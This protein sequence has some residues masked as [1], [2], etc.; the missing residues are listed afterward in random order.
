[1]QA[2]KE[3][4]RFQHFLLLF[5]SPVPRIGWTN[6]R[7]QVERSSLAVGHSK[8]IRSARR[9]DAG[10]LGVTGGGGKKDRCCPFE[11]DAITTSHP[12]EPNVWIRPMAEKCFHDLHSFAIRKLN[13]T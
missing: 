5:L 13:F 10:D 4:R 7:G 3:L 9:Q 6:A 11:A 8:R 12:C 2:D 1:S